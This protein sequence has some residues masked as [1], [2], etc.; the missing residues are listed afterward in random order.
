MLESVREV[1]VAFI[2]EFWDDLFPFQSIAQVH[3][4]KVEAIATDC[5]VH[6]VGVV[7]VQDKIVI[8]VA[9]VLEFAAF[10]QQFL[11]ISHGTVFGHF[12]NSLHFDAVNC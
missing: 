8:E 6:H 4:G 1:P 11:G 3:H 2:I 5:L 10:L 9:V 12:L 7:L